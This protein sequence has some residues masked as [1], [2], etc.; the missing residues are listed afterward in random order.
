[1]ERLELNAESREKAGKALATMR[2][3]G[4]VPAILYGKKRD[5]KMLK[6]SALDLEK[7]TATEAGFNAIFDLKIDGKKEGLVRICDYQSDPMRRFF[8][9]VDFQIVDLKEK[10][11]V[12]VPVHLVGKAPGVKEGGILEQQR[13][14]LELKCLVTNIPDHLEIDVST[15]NIGDSIHADEV[16]LPEGVEFPHGTNFTIVAVVPPTKEEEPTPVVAEGA[17][18]VE[19]APVEGAAPA[20]GETKKAAGKEGEKKEEKKEEKK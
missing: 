15:L 2:R 9:H 10:V 1:M 16:K 3:T 6:V 19:G 12:E 8:L 14:T 4:F 18:P 20:E 7:A 5:P 11:E 17:V 13:R